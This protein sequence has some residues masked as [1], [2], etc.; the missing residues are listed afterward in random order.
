M[1]SASTKASAT[2]TGA[3]SSQAERRR[4]LRYSHVAV[5][6]AAP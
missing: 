6:A 3:V 1:L 2:S 5:T 4:A